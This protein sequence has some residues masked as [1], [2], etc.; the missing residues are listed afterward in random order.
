MRLAEGAFRTKTDKNGAEY[1]LHRLNGAAPAP[2]PPPPPAGPAP[3][4]ADAANLHAVYGAL[5]AA[6]PLCRAHR[7]NLR[8]RGLADA[9]IDRRGYRTLPGQGRARTLREM[10]ERFGDVVLRVPGVVTRERDGRRYLTLAGPAGLLIP[11]RDVAS[12]VV[13]LLVRR[14]GDGPAKY[15]WV[16]ST[17]DGGPGPGAPVHVPRGVAGPAEVVRVTEGA[18]KADVA[19]ALSGLPTVGL[20]GVTTWRP[21]LPILRELGARTVRL[22]LD[23]DAKD[24]PPVARALGALA[25]GLA[26]EGLAVELEQ[27]P[28]PHKGIDD[29][30]AAGDAVEVLAGDAAR[31][32][33]AAIVGEGTAGQPDPLDRLDEV[34]A[35]GAEALYGAGEL[36]RALARLAVADPAEYACVRLRLLRAGVRL[37][38]FDA[39]LAPYRQELRRQCPPADTS[40]AAELAACAGEAELFHA[41]DGEAFARVPAG[42]HAEVW[43]LRARGFRRWL[44]QSYYRRTGRTPAAQ[45]LQ[46]ALG[47][48]EGRAA[49]DGPERSVF[50]R[51]GGAEGAICLDLA[52]AQWR[53]V[54]VDAAGWSVLTRPPVCFRRPRGMLPLPAPVGGGA[55][56]ELRQ[57]VNVRSDDDWRLLVAWL[58]AA[59]RT[60]GP[61]PVLVLHG[62]Q[63]SAKSTTARILRELI[64]PNAA[65]LRA[66]PREVRDLMIA[67]TNGWTV[68]LD[69]L[70]HLPPWLSDALCR[71]ATGGGFATRELYSDSE[72]AIFDAQRPVILTGVEELATRGDLLDRCLILHLVPIPDDRR[73]TEADLWAAFDAARPRILGALLSTVA[74]AMRALPGTQLRLLPRLADFAQWATAAEGALGWPAGAFLAA[75]AG[76]R[77]E[78]NEVALETSPV[79][80]AV[81]QLAA[82]GPWQGTA[83]DL[84][85]QLVEIAGEQAARAPAWPKSPRGLGGALRRLAPNLRRAGVEVSMWRATDSRRQRMVSIRRA[86][87]PQ[88]GEGTVRPNRPD[89]SGAGD[90]PGKAGVSPDPAPD[91][92]PD[93]NRA[94]DA[95]RT[96]TGAPGEPDNAAVSDCPDSS[97]AKS[98]THS[99]AAPRRRSGTI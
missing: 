72:E 78:A 31:Q 9:E 49:Y 25:G 57:Y 17:R 60:R 47:V 21:A 55:V 95:N 1:H 86:E 12:R 30:L 10:R 87:C 82:G 93:A 40:T 91:A 99:N 45:A 16:S 92:N 75:Y 7:D 18:L 23:A 41:P 84:L 3:D 97:D 63:G 67:A 71:L 42:D 38:D 58:L 26:A 85:R 13:A 11:A 37:K 59:Y 2:C 89:A 76:N 39:A 79:A 70:S 96:Q 51:V 34:L 64:D 61:Y 48:L 81:L 27:W 20:P 88:N 50:T 43:P 80:G 36:M 74:A 35:E 44:V 46:D 56:E 94:P 8:G 69:N 32:A 83:A 19:H 73:R 65:P 22:A 5:L 53:A 28:A 77:A 4:R 15:V 29:A 33:I 52:D 62:E 6:L 68:A 54:R 90:D 66:E 14:E 24:K 98:S